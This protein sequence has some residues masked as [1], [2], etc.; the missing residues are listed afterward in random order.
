MIPRAGLFTPN[1]PEAQ[2]LTGL[3]VQTTDDLR[4]AGE[5]LLKLGAAAVLMKGGHA[6]GAV[7]TDLL[8]GPETRVFRAPR[9]A[10]RNTH[11]TGCTLSAA[12]AAHLALGADMLRAVQRGR[13]YVRA[14]LAAGAHACIGHGHGP[15][16]HGFDPQPMH[17]RPLSGVAAH[18]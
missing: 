6:A 13:D 17:I 3:P 18:E 1:A 15:V 7:C 10:T 16:N 12:I 5:A 14:A 8:I 4:R 11:G 2:V 9:I